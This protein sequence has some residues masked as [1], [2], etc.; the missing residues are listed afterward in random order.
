MS[1]DSSTSHRSVRR[2]RVGLLSTVQ[3]LCVLLLFLAVNF[4]SSQYHR[5]FDLSDDLGFTLSPSTERYLKSEALQTREAPI[6][7]IVAFR[8]D[9]PLYEKIRPVAEEFARL[10]EG[11]IL[12]ELIDPIRANDAAESLAAEY[13]LVFN[14][15][16]VVIDARPE[17][18]A[19]AEGP[20]VAL[21]KHV[22]V[23]RLEDMVIHEVGQD[24]QRRIRGFIGEDALRASLV[25]AIEGK[26]RKL[27]VFADKSDLTSVE[28]EGIWDTLVTRFATQ[29]IV[30]E[31]VA[32]S[33]ID[34]VPEDVEAVAIIGA[35]FELTPKDLAVLENYWQRPKSAVLVTTGS[36]DVPPRLRSFL[37]SY[38]V[39]PQTDR[40]IATHGGSV[41]TTVTA[42]FME[43]YDFL[44]DL[45]EKST[46][47][48][49][50]TRSLDVR[51]NADDLLNKRILPYAIVKAADS[52]WGEQ[53]FPSESPTRDPNAE[54]L[55]PYV[56]AAVV[57]GNATD[58][59]FAGDVSRMIVIGNTDFLSP[60]RL[61]QTN[62]DFLSSCAN[63]LI[64][65][66]DLT[67]EGPANLR[68]YKLPLLTPQVT[69]INRVNLILLPGLILVIGG[70]VWS[71]R[72]S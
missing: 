66:D 39:T 26:P 34:S 16:L 51:E 63:W 43:N 2:F 47:L 8:S 10:S 27:W 22:Q 25:N 55:A 5:P 18:T 9:S 45:G 54:T 4:L 58:D 65:R 57:R 68:L 72:R 40:V 44:R 67:G 33:E 49:G 56:A 7:M 52:F 19:E 32:L 64:G 36:K 15:D 46:L 35:I 23:V 59:R 12:L 53:D 21:S 38:G 41:Q 17:Q 3:I 71:T 24:N 29:N 6:R 37:R 13:H 61:Q 1:Q 62:M 69:F 42:T 11:K 50:H 48:E 70:L 60:K 31:R 30:A 28:S 20:D 14:Q